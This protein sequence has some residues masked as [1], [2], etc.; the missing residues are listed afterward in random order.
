MYV[1]E[2][3]RIDKLVKE[4]LSLVESMKLFT[5][6]Q[7]NVEGIV[8]YYDFE[9]CKEFAYDSDEYLIENEYFTWQDI[10]DLQMANVKEEVYKYED[11]KSINEK[12]RE[13]GIKDISEIILSNECEEILDDVYSDLVNCIKTRAIARQSNFLFEKIFEVYLSGGWPCGWEGN[14]PNGKMK[15]FY[16]KE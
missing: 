3:E 5:T 16:V 8:E 9:K 14:F 2:N 12:L 6:K 4:S 11:Y 13:I 1:K 10:K 7:K 15:V